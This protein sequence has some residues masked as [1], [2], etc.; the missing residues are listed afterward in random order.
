MRRAPRLLIADDWRDYSL[1]DAGSGRKL[2][3][4]GDIVVDRPDPQALWTPAAPH[5]EWRADAVFASDSDDDERGAWRFSGRPPPDEWRLGWDG[6]RLHAR[7]T[8]FRHMGLFP[9]HSVHWRWA[10]DLITARREPVRV[11]NLFGYTGVMS[12]ACAAAGAEVVHLDASAKSIAQAKDN[13]ASS[14]LTDRPVRWI[15]DDAMKFVER[16]VRRGRTYDGVVL[17]PPKYGRGPKNEVWRFDEDLPRMLT[18]VRRL[19]SD[20]PLFVIASAYAV[21]L[22]F[23]A[24]GQALECALEGRGGELEAGEMALPV[25][26]GDRVLPTALFARWRA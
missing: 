1:L 5:S 26:G 13:Q 12:L 18:S 21:R 7:C 20:R 3:R 9:E 15:C 17:D 19:L 25:A 11:L 14:G 6:L 22:S 16:E 8:P 24:L 4:F 10:A 23:L 2:E